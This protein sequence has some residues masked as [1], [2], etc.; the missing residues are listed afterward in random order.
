MKTIC[1]QV[2]RFPRFL[3]TVGKLIRSESWRRSSF[4]QAGEAHEAARTSG[5][6]KMRT[7]RTMSRGR[8]DGGGIGVCATEGW[9]LWMNNSS[10][11]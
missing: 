2:L 7:G 6:L 11:D 5:G 10:H 3:Q 1:S 4:F 8:A 9:E